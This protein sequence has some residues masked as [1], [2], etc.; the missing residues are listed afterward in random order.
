MALEL[1]PA[2][3]APLVAQALNKADLEILAW[4]VSPLGA[5][6]SKVAGIGEGVWRIS[7]SAQD[8]RGVHPWSLILKG[9]HA[10]DAFNARDPTSW[11][12]WKR[13]PLA[14]QSGLLANL[15]GALVAPR[16][17]AIQERAD[18][19]V[20]LWMEDVQESTSTWTMAHYNL[21]ARHLGQFNGAY[22]SGY[23]LP[24]AE[25]WLTWGRV[26]PWIPILPSWLALADQYAQTPVIQGIFPG[27]TLARMQRL[28][29]DPES[30][31]QAFERLPVCFCHHDAFRRNLL[32]RR[33][34][35]GEDETVAIDW[36]LT[37]FG[38]VGEEAGTTTAMSTQYVDVPVSP[39][40]ELDQAVFSGYIEGLRASGWRG[41]ARLARLGYTVN[42]LLMTT[43]G[44]FVTAG[45][46]QPP[47]QMDA[48]L[49]RLWDE[50]LEHTA[51][52]LPFFL[53][54]GDE[55]YALAAAM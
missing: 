31:L 36:A 51:Q 18:D 7:G 52:M 48:T 44:A 26:R 6:G 14:F 53:D 22:L 11:N 33:T 34:V 49:R 25:T 32:A 30:L 37:G 10:S 8:D 27:E 1:Q 20:W 24:K 41:D 21:A 54:L 39:V 5:Q 43:A 17:Y 46:L 16:C 55:A 45:M 23:P 40:R 47:E 2:E 9:L 29:T 3:L 38:R 15:P 35:A 42:A 13:E 28:W 12:Y 19:R 50:R 4:R